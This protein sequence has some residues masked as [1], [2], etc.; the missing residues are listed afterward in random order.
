[1]QKL[2]GGKDRS[3]GGDQ[4]PIQNAYQVLCTAWRGRPSPAQPPVWLHPQ[5]PSTHNT[6]GCGGGAQTE[7]P[8]PQGISSNTPS[9]LGSW[10]RGR[11][12]RTCL[13]L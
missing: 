11:T 8:A 6:R 12:G 4:E 13:V 3:S 9:N 10:D 2:Q 7:L 1:M 5:P